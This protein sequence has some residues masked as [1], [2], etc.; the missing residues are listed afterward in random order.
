MTKASGAAADAALAVGRKLL[1]LAAGVTAING[2]IHIEKINGPF[3]SKTGCNASAR[4]SAPGSD[5]RLNKA[6]FSCTRAGP[7]FRPVALLSG[8]LFSLQH[9]CLNLIG[10]E[11]QVVSDPVEHLTLLWVSRQISDQS[12]FGCVRSQFFDLRQIIFHCRTHP[13]QV[14]RLRWLR[15]L[16][17]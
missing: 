16:A 4:S 1:E 11:G 2:R 13:K 9:C 6:G 17:G 5:T 12:R 15:W 3:L 10:E 7:T 8:G 14:R